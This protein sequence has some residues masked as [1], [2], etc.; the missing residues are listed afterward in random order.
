MINAFN[1][2]N[3]EMYLSYFDQFVCYL[4]LSSVSLYHLKF[5][6]FDMDFALYTCL[7]A[8]KPHLFMITIVWGNVLGIIKRMRECISRSSGL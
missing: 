5:S 3:F 7:S 6:T 2:E 8:G 4:T 1:K